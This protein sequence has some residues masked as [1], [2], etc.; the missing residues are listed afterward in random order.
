VRSKIRLRRWPDRNRFGSQQLGFRGDSGILEFDRMACRP[1]LLSK[2][3]GWGALAVPE[4]T[5]FSR[6]LIQNCRVPDIVGK[7]G[8]N[9]AYVRHGAISAEELWIVHWFPLHDDDLG[10]II[11]SLQIGPGSC[12][13]CFRFGL[14]KQGPA[15]QFEQVEYPPIQADDRIVFPRRDA[16]LCTWPRGSY[17]PSLRLPADLSSMFSIR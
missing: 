11:S 7:A 14:L 5:G 10:S 3:R 6:F 9:R 4:T 15:R 1:N 16:T 12:S 13:D 2:R 8:K 17:H